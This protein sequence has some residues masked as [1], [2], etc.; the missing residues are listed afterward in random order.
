MGSSDKARPYLLTNVIQNYGWG[1]KNEAAFI[2]RLMAM[3]TEADKPYAELWL[4]THPNGPSQIIDPRRGSLDLADWI[5]ED[6]GSRLSQNRAEEFSGK[7]PYL[8]KVL[9]AEKMLSIQTHPNQQQAIELHAADPV[10]YP[11]DNHKPE[12]AIAIDHL[13]TLVGFI[14]DRDFHELL[15]K[16]PELGDLLDL[17]EPQLQNGVLKLLDLWN[18]SPES[19]TSRIETIH[20]KV[21][22]ASVRTQNE[23]LLLDQVSEHG[24]GDIGILF[25]LLLNYEHLEAGE[26]I[27]LG[28]GIPHAYLKGNI[29]ECMANSDNV[30]RLGLTPKFCDTE[31]LKDVLDF[32]EAPEIHITPDS[33]GQLTE[34]NTPTKEFVVKSIALDEGDTFELKERSELTLFLVLQ[35]EIKL[36]WCTENSSCCGIYQQGDAFVAPANLREYTIQARQDSLVYLVDLP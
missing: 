20:E 17:E 12:I 8:F 30:V 13:D 2:A 28:P 33:D 32:S 5:A 1:Q 34:Y 6:P 25:I 29:I 16:Y 26:A 7:L 24:T 35:G 19:I 14:S 27:F 18:H 31:A 4:G 22:A 23:Q 11:D 15:T 21:L 9:S 10:H 36:Y 3:E